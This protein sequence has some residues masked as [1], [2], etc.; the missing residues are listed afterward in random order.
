MG[1][2]LLEDGGEPFEGFL[3]G[4][5]DQLQIRFPIRPAE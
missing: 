2:T 5:S 1:F 4:T 3:W